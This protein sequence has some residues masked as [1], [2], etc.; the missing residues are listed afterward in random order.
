MKK[1][2]FWNSEKLLSIAAI[3]ISVGTFFTM[4]YQTDLIRKQQYASVLPYLEVWNSDMSIDSY[5]LTLV[6]NG[7]GPA[8]V[9]EIRVK[10][11]DEVFM[12]DPLKFYQAHIAEMDTVKN[13]YYTNI[14]EGR[15]I[16]AGAEIKMLSV[17]NSEENAQRFREWFAGG[18][19]L[20]EIEYSSIYGEKWLT[21][22]SLPPQKI[23]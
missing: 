8:F 22:I 3:L 16:P 4:I 2:K 6:N 14:W 10:Y 17:K 21:G 15:L 23:D 18:K 5:T 1:R 20:V 19:A 7:V 13:Y 11:G 12:G 9:E